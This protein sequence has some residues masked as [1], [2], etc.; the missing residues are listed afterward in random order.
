MTFIKISLLT[1]NLSLYVWVSFLSSRRLQNFFVSQQSVILNMKIFIHTDILHFLKKNM[2]VGD[3]VS[4][5]IHSSNK[6]VAGL[7]EEI[8]GNVATVRLRSAPDAKSHNRD[9][10]ISVPVSSLQSLG[11]SSPTSRDQLLGE[12]PASPSKTN[13]ARS[14]GSNSSDYNGK[15]EDITDPFKNFDDGGAL[16]SSVTVLTAESS[17]ELKEKKRREAT[18]TVLRHGIFSR[19][20][21]EFLSPI[22]SLLR[23]EKPLFSIAFIILFVLADL[24][25]TSPEA[26]VQTTCWM[27]SRIVRDEHRRALPPPASSFTFGSLTG[28]E[29]SSSITPPSSEQENAASSL[30]RAFEQTLG[31][32]KGE[33]SVSNKKKNKDKDEQNHK[34]ANSK[35]SSTPVSESSTHTSSTTAK[36]NILDTTQ[37]LL[38][39]EYLPEPIKAF[40]LS[41]EKLLE[42][43]V[44]FRARIFIRDAGLFMEDMWIAGERL[45]VT[46]ENTRRAAASSLRGYSLLGQTC[47]ALDRNP[48]SITYAGV[49]QENAKFIA[50][51]LSVFVYCVLL[52]LMWSQSV[53]CST[54]SD[55][56]RSSP[57]AS[58]INNNSN[59]NSSLNQKDSS[60]SSSSSTPEEIAKQLEIEE[61][62]RLLD[63]ADD[64]YANNNEEY[65][66]NNGD[67]DTDSKIRFRLK[68]E[69]LEYRRRHERMKKLELEIHYP[70]LALRKFLKEFRKPIVLH[71]VLICVLCI[72]SWMFRIVPVRPI[73][74]NPPSY[75]IEYSHVII[76]NFFSPFQDLLIGMGAPMLNQTLE[77]WFVQSLSVNVLVGLAGWIW[78]MK[79]RK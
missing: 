19:Y 7:V 8:N 12:Y 66:D 39:E 35:K 22:A 25:R 48:K 38:F 33:D 60:S 10:T 14:P 31:S 79:W 11:V 32:N 24:C 21:W 51:R 67:D 71:I 6:I 63:D 1:S 62:I 69:K 27:V 36:S 42:E 17:P 49:I 15:S 73:A 18:A 78:N 55:Q 76:Q 3:Y 61:E 72:S 70:D 20:V 68:T 44:I 29:I 52:C 37:P 64:G 40:L 45:V 47:S 65:F 77:S 23:C 26:V 5:K 56:Q 30:K 13:G 50:N 4:V 59:N 57:S 75:T 74:G 54:T 16:A 2:S 46:D 53:R 9:E 58:F 34:N 43:T 41:V 28:V